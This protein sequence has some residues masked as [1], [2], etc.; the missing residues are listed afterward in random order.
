MAPAVRKISLAKVVG[1]EVA[2]QHRNETA[3]RCG[4]KRICMSTCRKHR[5]SGPV[6]EVQ[7]F[8]NGTPLWR[9]AHVQVKPPHGRTSF[10]SSDAQ[11]GHAAVARSTWSSQ[12]TSWP[13]L[14][15]KFRCPKRAR[16][17]GEEHMVKSKCTKH[18][19]AGPFFQ[20][21]VPKNGTPLRRVAHL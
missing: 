13:D 20:V 19:M 8:K 10:S 4:V 2:V 12:T 9:E 17:C 6:F 5:M 16:R 7:M 21:Q 3:R 14:F 1:A 15:F 11:K 18:G